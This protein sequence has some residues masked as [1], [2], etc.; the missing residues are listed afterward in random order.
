MGIEEQFR[1]FE[2]FIKTDLPAQKSLHLDKISQDLSAGIRETPEGNF[3]VKETIYGPGDL[4][5]QF[6][7]SDLD[8]SHPLRFDSFSC[9]PDEGTFN[10]KNIVVIDTE[11]TGL[12]GGVG[13]VPFLV[14]LGFFRDGTYV[15]RQHFLP[16]YSEEHGF[17]KYMFDDLPGNMIVSF[18]GK[19][20]DLPLLTNRFLIQRTGSEFFSRKHLD[21]LFTLRRFFR[22]KLPDCTLKTAERALLEFERL[23]DIPSEQIPQTYFNYLQTGETSEIYQ[24]IKHNIWD[25]V[26]TMGVMVELERYVESAEKMDKLSDVDSWAIGKFYLQ[27]KDY[28]R[29]FSSFSRSEG[30]EQ[31]FHFKNLFQASMISKKLCD[32]E[33]AV[34]YW[35]MLSESFNPHYFAA[36]EEMAK[37]FEHRS[38]EF[39]KAISCC[40]RAL[41]SIY[42]VSQLHDQADFEQ[43]Q[44]RFSHRLSRLQTKSS[45]S[46]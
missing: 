11:T 31:E 13:T 20:F 45:K 38:R 12:S 10:L 43:W 19:A 24:V 2:K 7:F 21:V 18:N 22:L 40:R 23:N 37:L 28:D 35:K 44:T 29:A 33:T 42:Q 27:R 32:F 16:D 26:S 14:G 30:T 3:L 9:P 1:R 15:V 39:D 46:K 25:I 41:D 17:Y 6:S 5:G 34:S 36:L 8:L 4:H